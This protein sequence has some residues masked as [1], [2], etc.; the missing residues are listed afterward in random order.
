MWSHEDW[1]SVH[2]VR[3]KTWQDCRPGR[4]GLNAIPQPCISHDDSS[5]GVHLRQ[6]GDLGQ[7][8]GVSKKTTDFLICDF[9]ENDDSGL[10][11]LKL[12]CP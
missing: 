4:N 12:F 8:Q 5:L 9:I 7:F 1:F 11:E 3:N 2:L 6:G 10:Y